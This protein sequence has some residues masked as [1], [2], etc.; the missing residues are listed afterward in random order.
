MKERQ[1]ITTSKPSGSTVRSS[2]K[3]S[4][5]N[6]DSAVSLG[7]TPLQSDTQE[8]KVA[9][10][11]SEDAESRLKN[12]KLRFRMKDIGTAPNEEP[13]ITEEDALDRKETIAMFFH[14]PKPSTPSLETLSR[15][16]SLG[17]TPKSLPSQAFT[18]TASQ[19][20][21]TNNSFNSAHTPKS[22]KE[23]KGTMYVTE[24]WSEKHSKNVRVKSGIMLQA[25]EIEEK[26]DMNSTKHNIGSRRFSS[27]IKSRFGESASAMLPSKLKERRNFSVDRLHTEGSMPSSG[28][29]RLPG[30][31]QQPLSSSFVHRARH[32]RDLSHDSSSFEVK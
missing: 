4:L 9:L 24:L 27:H 16:R 6:L 12:L 17:S 21:R 32:Y 14:P 3:D 20:R 2:A 15:H 25:K 28:G 13:I 1:L 8:R 22:T 18:P 7:T 19:F 23:K 10:G 5:S 31:G 26:L 30:K 29:K 11:E